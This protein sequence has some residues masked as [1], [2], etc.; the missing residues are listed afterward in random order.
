MNPTARRAMTAV[1][2]T[3]LALGPMT[4]AAHADDA[5]ADVRTW[6]LSV[7]LQQRDD[8][9]RAIDVARTDLR[10][11]VQ[12]ARTA[13]RTTV[14]GIRLQV[15]G[16]T[17]AQRVANRAR[18]DRDLSMAVAAARSSL[19]TARS[20]Y[21]NRLNAAFSTWAPAATVPRTLVDIAPWSGIGDG[22]WLDLERLRTTL[23][24]RS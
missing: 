17:A 10:T 24:P 2:A 8:L 12:N 4:G 20:T 7:D 1:L 11:S 14:D 5:P 16:D 22:S 13:L 6:G 15:L 9:V 18:Y 19:Q 3:V 23:L 21:T